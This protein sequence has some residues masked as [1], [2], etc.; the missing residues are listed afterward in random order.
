MTDNSLFSFPTKAD[1]RAYVRA[2]AKYWWLLVVAGIGRFADTIER[3]VRAMDNPD[4]D[5]PG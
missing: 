2:L 3:L 1:F 5:I 4:F